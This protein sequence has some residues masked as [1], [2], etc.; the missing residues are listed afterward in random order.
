MPYTDLHMHVGKAAEG[1]ELQQLKRL[2]DELMDTGELDVYTLTREQLEA[3]AA[4]FAPTVRPVCI[5]FVHAVHADHR[6]AESHAHGS[7]SG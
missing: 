4:L 7:S 3:A 5:T 2:A 6:P 1:T